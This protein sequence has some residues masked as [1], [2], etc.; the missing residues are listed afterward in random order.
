MVSGWGIDV[1]QPEEIKK[2]DTTL[3]K[4]V[5]TFQVDE[6]SKPPEVKVAVE[7][8]GQPFDFVNKD[9]RETYIYLLYGNS[10][11]GK[12]YTSMTFPKPLIIIDTESRAD[13]IRDEYFKEEDIKIFNPLVLKHESGEKGELVDYKATIERLNNFILKLAKLVKERKYTVRTVVIDTASDLW[14][15]VINWGVYTLANKV[16]KDG[17]AKADPDTLK[18]LNQFDWFIPKNMHYKIFQILKI[19]TNYGVNIVFTAR[20]RELPDYAKELKK[21][22]MGKLYTETFQEKIRCEKEL[23]F[24]S[25]II[26]RQTLTSDNKRLSVVEKSFKAGIE[27]KVMEDLTYDKIKEVLE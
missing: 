17:K 15:F 18:F 27:Q 26:I 25:D 11:S 14:N 12:T 8:T 1:E 13:I 24:N 19:L 5:R 10:G 9:R 16:T 20:P 6:N 23:P 7:D 21:R 2:E 22:Q 3:M 4:E